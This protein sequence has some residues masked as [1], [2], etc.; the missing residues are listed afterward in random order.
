MPVEED[1]SLQQVQELQGVQCNSRKHF[2]GCKVWLVPLLIEVVGPDHDHG[3]WRDEAVLLLMALNVCYSHLVT[4]VDLD[5]G[6]TGCA[7]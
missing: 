5:L 4:G 3:I 2:A 1:A 7:L 6:V